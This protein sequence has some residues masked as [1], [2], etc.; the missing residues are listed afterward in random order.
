MD[1]IEGEEDTGQQ[2]WEDHLHGMTYQPSF[3][4]TYIDKI[5]NREDAKRLQTLMKKEKLTRSDL[6]EILYLLAG[7]ETKLINLGDWDRYY[8]GKYFAWIRDFIS[9]A[10][11]V[12]EYIDNLDEMIENSRDDNEKKILLETREMMSIVQQHDLHNSK[13]LVDVFLFL[14]R[15]TLSIGATAFDT[16]STSR[17]EYM[18]PLQPKQQNIEER[19]RFFFFK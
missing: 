13:F 18:Y 16:L 4:K 15:S 17:F 6:L 3:E 10:E 9:K 1:D 12:Y 5:L 8:L 2:P 19:R 7:V 11:L 14:A